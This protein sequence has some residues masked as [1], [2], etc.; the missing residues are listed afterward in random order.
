MK[1]DENL[2]IIFTP[3]LETGQ[4]FWNVDSI[5]KKKGDE[6]GFRHA[7]LRRHV[8][9]YKGTQYRREDLIWYFKY[10]SFPEER[11]FHVNGNKFDDRIDN[12]FLKGDKNV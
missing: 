8:I 12:L 1:T 7:Q 2:K 6:A 9:N 4:I 11:L 3:N 5:K 10:G